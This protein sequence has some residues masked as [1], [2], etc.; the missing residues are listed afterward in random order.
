MIEKNVPTVG[1][2]PFDSME[3][4]DS[5]SVMLEKRHKLSVAMLRYSKKTGTK[6]ISRRMED[7]SIR[8]WRVK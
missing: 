5:F 7:G 6:F 4:G 2:Y 3:V 8:V 1:Y